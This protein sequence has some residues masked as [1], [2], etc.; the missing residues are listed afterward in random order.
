[1]HLSLDKEITYS[2]RL[3]EETQCFA[4]EVFIDGK[5]AGTVENRGRGGC[6][7]YYPHTL[8]DTLAAHGATLAPKVMEHGTFDYDA[9][10]VIDDLLF[11]HLIRT[12][13]K[14]K[15]AK[16]VLFQ[17]KDGKLMASPKYDAAT[18]VKAI[19]HFTAKGETVL[20]SMDFDAALAIYY[21]K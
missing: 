19:Q 11:D 10:L 5:K 2:T 3:S 13:L 21:T 7:M 1:M 9:D 8:R 4:A 15:L 14:K 12:E 6:H 20:N 18:L 16:Q 17:T